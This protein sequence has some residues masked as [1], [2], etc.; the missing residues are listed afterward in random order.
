M[1]LNT[2]HY[3]GILIANSFAELSCLAQMLRAVSQL[4]RFRYDDTGV[5]LNEIREIACFHCFKDL[6]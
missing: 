3:E 2:F 1:L 4:K 6:K 5:A